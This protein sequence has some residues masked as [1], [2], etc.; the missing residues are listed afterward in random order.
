MVV[1]GI[2]PYRA[3][4]C[5]ETAAVEGLLDLVDLHGPGIANRTS[6][7]A[8]GDVRRLGVGRGNLVP[9]EASSVS[10]DKAVIARASVGIMQS[11]GV[12]DRKTYPCQKQDRRPSATGTRLAA[13]DPRAPLNFIRLTTLATPCRGEQSTATSA[14]R[15]LSRRSKMDR[16]FQSEMATS[17][18]LEVRSHPGLA[19]AERSSLHPRIRAIA[20]QASGRRIAPSATFIAS[21]GKNG[22][23]PTSN[24]VP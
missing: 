13:A 12:S 19:I 18:D 17:G 15:Q 8:D 23:S 14:V 9:P 6:E 21:P 3:L 22:S 11:G 24:A 20:F 10:A 7:E 4:R 16:Q 1:P 2:D 5:F